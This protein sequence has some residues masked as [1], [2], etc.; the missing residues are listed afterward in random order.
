MTI[1]DPK[2]QAFVTYK[3]AKLNSALLYKKTEDD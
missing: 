3:A 1:T 2:L